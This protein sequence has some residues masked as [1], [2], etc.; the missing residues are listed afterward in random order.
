MSPPLTP[1]QTVGPY[2]AL[3]LPWEDG[4]YAAAQGAPGAIR[5]SGR[6]LDG[7]G[8]PIP[9]ALVET[10]QSSPGPHD[11]FR[12]FARCP[13]DDDGRWFAVTLR[14]RPVPGPAGTTQ[15]P[16][17]DVSVFARGMLHRVVTRIYFAD[18]ADANATDPVLSSVP[19][20]RRETLLA[21]LEGEDHR[22]DI[23]IQG[24]GETVFFDV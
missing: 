4:P 20:N 16:H 12:G 17:L 3:G 18:E 19:A 14:P 5:I 6:V 15:A 10:W 23:R 13:S 1:S 11:G 2:L 8:D 7:S 21:Q 22:F 9:D 24:I